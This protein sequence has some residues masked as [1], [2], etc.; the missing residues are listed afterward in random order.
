MGCALVCHQHEIDQ[1]NGLFWINR[2]SRRRYHRED[3]ERMEYFVPIRWLQTEPLERGVTEI[4]M[5]G[6]Q[7]T[8][9]KPTTPNA[10]G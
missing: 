7:N 10:F 3:E 6:N 1:L 5:F 4:G 8:V 9:C 2:L